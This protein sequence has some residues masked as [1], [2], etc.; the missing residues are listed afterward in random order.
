M[1]TIMEY[2]HIAIGVEYGIE[3]MHYFSRVFKK[4]KGTNPSESRKL[5]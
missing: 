2:F 4:L 5:W 1:D 3:D